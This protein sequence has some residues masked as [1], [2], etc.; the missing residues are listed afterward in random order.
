MNDYRFGVYDHKYVDKNDNNQIQ[1]S[2]IDG[3]TSTG[4]PEI[5]R[6]K[7]G[8]FM[9]HIEADVSIFVSC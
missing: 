2:L 4:M 5:Q 9:F 7:P 8:V 3:Q 1:R 6:I